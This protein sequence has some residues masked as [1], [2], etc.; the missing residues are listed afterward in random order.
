MLRILFPFL[1]NRID[2]KVQE[3]LQGTQYTHWTGRRRKGSLQR[4]RTRTHTPAHV[5][6]YLR[7]TRRQHQIDTMWSA[8][9]TTSN[10]GGQSPHSNDD[11]MEDMPPEEEVARIRAQEEQREEFFVEPREE[12]L[13]RSPRLTQ[14]PILPYTT[15]ARSEAPPAPSGARANVEE[16]WLKMGG[17][18]TQTWIVID[19]LSQCPRYYCATGESGPGRLADLVE[20]EVSQYGMHK[21]RVEGTALPKPV[22]RA[23]RKKLVEC[24]KGEAQLPNKE[25]WREFLAP[26]SQMLCIEYNCRHCGAKCKVF[27]KHGQLMDTHERYGR[28]TCALLGRQ[29]FAGDM[30]MAGNLIEGGNTPPTARPSGEVEASIPVTRSRISLGHTMSRIS[31]AKGSHP[32]VTSAAPEEANIDFAWESSDPPGSPFNQPTYPELHPPPSAP[33]VS[34]G[35]ATSSMPPVYSIATPHNPPRSRNAPIDPGMSEILKAIAQLTREVGELRNKKAEEKKVGKQNPF[36][37]SLRKQG[38]SESEAGEEGEELE[39]DDEVWGESHADP[40]VHKVAKSMGKSVGCRDYNG[41]AQTAVFKAWCETMKNYIRVHQVKPGPGQITVASWNLK[42]RALAW[43]EN[44]LSTQKYKKMRTLDDLFM[45]LRKQ[46]RPDDASEQAIAHWSNLRQTRDVTSYMDEVDKLHLSHPLCEVAEFG[47]AR[48]GLRREIR[49]IIRRA[50]ADQDREWLTLKELRDLARSAEIE[51]CDPIFMRGER[52]NTHHVHAMQGGE[53]GGNAKPKWAKP[54]STPHTSNDKR[55]GVCNM[56][57]HWTR[58][59]RHKKEK[60]CWRCGGDHRIAECT[61]PFAK[62]GWKTAITPQGGPEKEDSTPRQQ[63][64]SV[65]RAPPPR[66]SQVASVLSLTYPVKV[67]GTGKVVLAT[68]DTGAQCS[69]IRADVFQQI[70]QHT[71]IKLRE[72][73]SAT[74]PIVKGVSGEPL[75]ILGAAIVQFYANGVHT[76]VQ[77]WVIE[78]MDPQLILGLPWIMK[79]K[80]TIEWETGTLVFP[81]KAQ[82]SIAGEVK[83]PTSQ[84][85]RTWEKIYLVLNGQTLHSNPPHTQLPVLKDIEGSSGE[86]GEMVN[87]PEVPRWVKGLVMKNE[88]LFAPLEGIPP[89]GR[90]KH[91]IELVEGAKPVMKRPYRLSEVQKQHA[92][93]QIRKALAEGWIQPSQ[94]AWGTA[95]LMVPKKDG[96]WRMCVDYREL[97]SLTI[98]DAYPMPRI[99]DLLHKLG[100]AQYFSKL[101]LQAGYH[102]IWMEP[103]DRSKTAFRIAEPIDGHCLFEWKVMPFGLKNAP[104]TF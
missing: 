82:W 19:P 11:S 44:L 46:F 54:N 85:G 28:A 60:G 50:L 21:C 75:K 32:F 16:K 3:C 66:S 104:P 80:P 2:P 7:T 87:P 86:E 96:S 8:R 59:C 26:D 36:S 65:V 74:S 9:R 4:Q 48:A 92:N 29:C 15:S 6:R 41:D 98:Q 101:D 100:G 34:P 22:E 97:N 47:L 68:V 14:Q 73:E 67:K 45:A 102:Q 37:F 38:E 89:D 25:Q 99:D 23:V 52:K 70:M 55:C 58:T 91:A 64:L 49:G 43:W 81:S 72:V 69:A 63:Y 5:Y 42:G 57:G 17:A 61:A 18:T 10:M 94:S 20:Q 35:P 77:L 78:G 53:M 39:D 103:Q 71:R 76:T 13:R 31:G 40:A 83:E 90:I 79:E 1:L 30:S 33:Y 62:T 51:K 56:Q 27:N 95:I 93:E 84:L 24:S 12:P 88:S